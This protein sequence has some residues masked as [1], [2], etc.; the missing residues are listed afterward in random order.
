KAL[1]ARAKIEQGADFAEVAAAESDDAGSKSRGGDLGAFGRGAMVAQFERAAF[2]A[3]LN[4]VVGPVR[5]D[6]GWHVIRVEERIS[7][8]P[9]DDKALDEKIRTD[10]YGQQV[11]AQFD[12]YVDELKRDA[13][14]DKRCQP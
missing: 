10:L 4:K 11:E 8:A 13:Y 9:L 14:I 1:A 12:Q 7:D 6:F 3:P 5:S 2:E